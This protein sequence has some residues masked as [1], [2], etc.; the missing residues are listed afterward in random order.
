MRKIESTILAIKPISFLIRRSKHIVLP[1][2][3]GLPLYDVIHYF[4]REIRNKSLGERAAAISFNFLL[5][6]PPFFIFLFTLVPYIP[7]SNV[8][9]TLYELAEDV[10]PNYNTYIIVR[11]M[12]H[13]FLYTHHNGLLSISF[14]MSFFASS[15]A[16]MG[17]ARSFNRKQAGFRRRKW[18]QK[19]LLALQLTAI[20][21][22][23][24][25]VTVI[26]IIAQGTV[27]HYIF[28]TLGITNTTVIS[29]AEMTRWVLIIF[30][31][32]SILSVLYRF[33]PATNKRWKFITAGSTLATILM[34]LVTLGFSVFVNNFSNYNKIYGSVGTLLILMIAV[35]LNS[36]TLL[37]GFE[38]NASIKYLKELKHA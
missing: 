17:V 27:L 12:I 34:I 18:W 15:N 29:L 5:A 21:V 19:R 10:T 16:V 33:V 8:E 24:L 3:E 28:D 13:D 4:F 36:L 22:F 14:G 31:F 32:Y 23:L 37:I 9:A 25:L 20:L 38:L 30:L 1:G 11:D 6:I 26:L 35:Y 7:M 2:F